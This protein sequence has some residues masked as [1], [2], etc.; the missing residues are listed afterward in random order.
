MYTDASTL[1]SLYRETI[2]YA[3]GGERKYI[4]Y[5]D[6]RGHFGHV[7]LQLTPRP[8]EPCSI[9]VDASCHLPEESCAVIQTALSGR[10][11]HGPV[12][13]LPL[14]GIEVRLTGG[15]YLPRHSY[16]EACAIAASMAYD[17]ALRRA[18]PF[19]VEPYVGIRLLVE[20]NSLQWKVKTLTSLLG[21]VHAIHSVTDVARLEVEIPVRLQYA[22][23]SALRLG[24]LD[25]FAL[26]KDRQYRSLSTSGKSPY[27]FSDA[28]DEWT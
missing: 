6:G 24:M 3:A 14:V 1:P 25:T 28:L 2:R 4:R 16:P 13:R 26:P 10:L 7:R 9:S 22:V 21:E 12:A 18:S 27:G 11:D 8:G 15:T 20:N 19:V 23:K 5:F 17:E